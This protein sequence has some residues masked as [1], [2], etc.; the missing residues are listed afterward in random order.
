[1][2]IKFLRC[3]TN[4]GTSVK[5]LRLKSSLFCVILVP[6]LGEE[7]GDRKVVDD[8]ARSAEY[9]TDKTVVSNPSTRVLIDTAFACLWRPLQT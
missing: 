7:G 5:I 8:P 4:F 1:M 6:G 3:S 2:S 9:R